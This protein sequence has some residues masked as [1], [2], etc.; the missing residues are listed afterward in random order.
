M[1]IIGDSRL[2]VEIRQELQLMGDFFGL[3][4]SGIVYPAICGHP[5]VFLHKTPDKLIVAPNAPKDLVNKLIEKNVK[6][7]FGEKELGFSYPATAFYN[8]TFSRDTIFCNQK[9]VDKSIIAAHLDKKI[10]HFN[11]GYVACNLLV[12][13]HSLL[14]SDLGISQKTDA[15][16]FPPE[17][18]ELEGVKHGFIGGACS[19]WHEQLLVFGTLRKLKSSEILYRFCD[20]NQLYIK[21]LYDGPLI[22][23]GGLVI[24]P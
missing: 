16:F 11:Q 14:T 4:S 15:L 8:A 20:E 23:G 12:G 10:Q 7:S 13:K 17:D 9:I 18:I 24:L 21:E 2:P 19:I 6:V 5:D 1:L 22:D 3:S